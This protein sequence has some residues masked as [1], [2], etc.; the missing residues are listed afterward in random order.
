MLSFS[1]LIVGAVW[2]SRTT[3]ACPYLTTRRLQGGGGHGG[4]GGGG[5][6]GGDSSS[7][8]IQQLLDNHQK[9]D[10]EVVR[11]EDGSI[12][13]R[14]VS[15]DSDVAKDLQD[16][17]EQMHGKVEANQQVRPWDP[18]FVELFDR[19]EEFTMDVTNIDQGVEIVMSAETDCGQALIESHAAV[20]TLFV[21]TGREESSK[22]HDVPAACLESVSEPE[23]GEVEQEN[24]PDT[25]EEL[26]TGTPTELVDD[27]S[28]AE[29]MTISL[30]S[31]GTV[32]ENIEAN[33]DSKYAA[34]AVDAISASPLAR[35]FCVTS[36]FMIFSV[37]WMGLA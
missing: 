15:T 21:E 4:G 12:R 14:T 17:V 30:G 28:T 24:E 1:M 25:D 6:G 22:S 3:D 35:P 26:D 18:F 33:D 13:T 2:L 32:G 20:V 8:L 10:R 36:S 9:V 5:G 11:N 37:A 27:D 31:N 19:H 7:V 29:N 34:S 16:H 23:A